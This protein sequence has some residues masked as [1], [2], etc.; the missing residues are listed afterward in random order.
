MRSYTTS[1]KDIVIEVENPQ[2]RKQKNLGI[3]LKNH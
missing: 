1:R 2:N 3:Y